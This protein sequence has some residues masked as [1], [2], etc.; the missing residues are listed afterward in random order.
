MNQGIDQYFIEIISVEEIKKFKPDS[1]VYKHFLKHSNS[2][3]DTTWLI[4]SNPFDIIGAKSAGF[5]TV[6]VQ[7]S[8]DATF[9][10]WNDIAPPLTITSLVELKQIIS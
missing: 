6:W 1:A 10:P 7:R 5:S 3:M 8:S 2:T 9:D 4:S